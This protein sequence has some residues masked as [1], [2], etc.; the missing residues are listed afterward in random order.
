MIAGRSGPS[1]MRARLCGSRLPIRSFDGPNL[2][3]EAAKTDGLVARTFMEQS[4]LL[5]PPI[6]EKYLARL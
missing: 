3:K 6:V 5:V 4:A 2:A 1:P